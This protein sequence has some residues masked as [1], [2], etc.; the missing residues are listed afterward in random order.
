MTGRAVGPN[1]RGDSGYRP[2]PRTARLIA[3]T[4]EDGRTCL[5]VQHSDGRTAIV[6]V[7]KVPDPA[8]ARAETAGLR[9][10]LAVHLDAQGTHVTARL[11]AIRWRYPIRRPIVVS[12]ALALALSRIP[13]AVTIW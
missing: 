11:S 5:T 3:L 10:L 7:D 6:W 12:T 13:V 1:L 2:R 9:R 4:V 8:R